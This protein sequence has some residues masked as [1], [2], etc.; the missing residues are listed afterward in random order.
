MPPQISSANTD[1]KQKSNK[2]GL[3]HTR[4]HSRKT[5]GYVGLLDLT[6][7]RDLYKSAE[8]QAFYDAYASEKRTSNFKAPGTLQSVYEHIEAYKDAKKF[9]QLKP[10][11]T[12]GW[13]GNDFY[14]HS[15]MKILGMAS[16][17]PV[18]PIFGPLPGEAQLEA[19]N[20]AWQLLAHYAY[21]VNSKRLDSL[22][23]NKFS[24]A[25]A[26]KPLFMM[27]PSIAAVEG[28]ATYTRYEFRCVWVNKSRIEQQHPEA[29]LPVSPF[30]ILDPRVYD[31]RQVRDGIRRALKC[32]QLGLDIRSFK[33]EHEQNEYS[34][35]DD[36]STVQELLRK[37]TT[38]E[39]LN[40]FEFYVSLRSVVDSDADIFELSTP[41]DE[42]FPSIHGTNGADEGA[43]DQTG[44]TSPNLDVDTDDGS[45]TETG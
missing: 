21:L 37:A 6:Q 18:A 3:Y 16:T 13:S 31:D 30:T 28:Q 26:V 14:A 22:M 11:K 40:E 12:D 5:A 33:V 25:P 39:E 23:G 15:V 27:P 9:G 32:P 24:N 4:T 29:D 43:Q 2:H 35:R 41:A 45:A 10:I 36:W 7:L 8:W 34:S 1:G 17:F 42:A 44:P 19:Y 38:E 20:R